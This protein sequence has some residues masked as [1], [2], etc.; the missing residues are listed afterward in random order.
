MALDIDGSR[1]TSRVEIGSELIGR[2]KEAVKETR[3]LCIIEDGETG[4]AANSQRDKSFR[5]A[6]EISAKIIDE[7]RQYES[8][9][10][11]RKAVP[12]KIRAGTSVPIYLS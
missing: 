5:N 11:Q 9:L 12:W 7:E 1:K 8:G 4:S 6:G 3:K 10:R 2:D